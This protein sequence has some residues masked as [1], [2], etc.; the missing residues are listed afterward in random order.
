MKLTIVSMIDGRKAAVMLDD[1]RWPNNDEE[2]L[3]ESVWKPVTYLNPRTYLRVGWCH[4]TSCIFSQLGVLMREV[5]GKGTK[6]TD[7]TVGFGDLD[8]QWT[9]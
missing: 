6:L 8:I 5:V 1:V 3:E 7:V 9:R 2:K 4:C